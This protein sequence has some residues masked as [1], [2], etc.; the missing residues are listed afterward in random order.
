MWLSQIMRW[1]FYCSSLWAW[2]QPVRMTADEVSLHAPWYQAPSVDCYELTLDT[3]AALSG[4]PAMHFKVGDQGSTCAWHPENDNASASLH[5]LLRA[6]PRDTKA[7]SRTILLCGGSTHSVVRYTYR[8]E[9]SVFYTN[10]GGKR[11]CE[12]R[13]KD[14]TGDPDETTWQHIQFCLIGEKCIDKIHQESTPYLLRQPPYYQV[15]YKPHRHMRSK[16]LCFSFALESENVLLTSLKSYSCSK[17]TNICILVNLDFKFQF[18]QMINSYDDSKSHASH[19]TDNLC[20]C[21][22]AIAAITFIAS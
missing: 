7:C 17:V 14:S 9:A 15:H 22:L 20:T 13:R 4:P 18:T 6:S 19:I 21:F 11:Q 10:T 5:L 3:Q 8:K 12:G 1:E 2:H 16:N